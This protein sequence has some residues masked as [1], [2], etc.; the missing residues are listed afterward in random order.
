MF[1]RVIAVTG[2]IG[3]GKSVVSKILRTIGYPVYDCDENARYL[4]DTSTD[5]K[6]CLTTEICPDAVHEDGTINRA[7][8]ARVVF[9]DATKL[10]V[11]NKIV[12]GTVTEH[13]KQ[14]I[15]GTT[16]PIFF[17]ETAILQ[18]AGL[19]AIVDEVWHVTAPEDIRIKRV[20]ARNGISE[21]EV[22]ARINNQ[23]D[24]PVEGAKII[25]NDGIAPILPQILALLPH[26]AD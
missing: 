7:A 26:S 9:N 8:I 15:A 1:P 3:S 24:N 25:T 19:D 16:S 21:D 10:A 2:G 14:T 20:M 12:H 6:G 4:M 5:I 11:L 17:F 23:N 18:T 22:R 13:L